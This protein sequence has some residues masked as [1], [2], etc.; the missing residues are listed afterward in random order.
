MYRRTHDLELKASNAGSPNF[1]L[2]GNE[3]VFHDGKT[4]AFCRFENPALDSFFNG[5]V[6]VSALER[7]VIAIRR[8]ST[9]PERRHFCILYMPVN[10][11]TSLHEHCAFIKKLIHSMRIPST[12]LIHNSFSS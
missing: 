10:T 4:V 7:R 3:N 2:E 9:G 11:D 6:N 8:F 12:R 5:F 1:S